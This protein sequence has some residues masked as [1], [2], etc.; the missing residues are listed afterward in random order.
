ML[1][2]SEDS[3]ESYKVFLGEQD[4][5]SLQYLKSSHYRPKK[6]LP[7]IILF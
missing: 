6:F 4:L 1:E 2:G 7:N 5:N 3:A